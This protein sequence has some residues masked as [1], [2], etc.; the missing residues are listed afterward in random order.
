MIFAAS[1]GQEINIVPQKKRKMYAKKNNFF[2]DFS[3]NNFDFLTLRGSKNH[4][5]TEILFET[6]SGTLNY[7]WDT[8]S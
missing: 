7:F 4:F 6:C 1:Q 5:G 8:I 3:S 2:C